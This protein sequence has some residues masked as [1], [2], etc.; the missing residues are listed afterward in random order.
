MYGSR[1][2]IPVKKLVKQRCAV[3]INSG[4]KGLR[5]DLLYIR[6]Q[7][8]SRRKLSTSVIKTNLRMAM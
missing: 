5:T 3:G 1:S 6:N 8:V 4:V 2:K 7:S